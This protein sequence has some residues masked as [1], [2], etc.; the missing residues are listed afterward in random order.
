MPVYLFA[1]SRVP[2]IDWVRAVLIF[3]IL[4]LLVYPS[5]NGYNSYM[6]RDTGSIGGIK[7]PLQPTRQLFIVTLILDVLAIGLSLLIGSLFTT[8]VFLYIMASKAYSFRGIR[9]KKYPIIGYLTV[10]IFQGAVI[11]FLVYHGSDMHWTTHVPLLPMIGASLLIGGFY[12]L[13]QI[14]QHDDDLK[15]GVKTISYMLGYKGT[16]LFTGIVYALAL[17][18]LGMYFYSSHL[19][20]RF[21][22]LVVFMSPVLVY[23][24][25]WLRKVWSN[26]EEANYD[27]TMRMNLIAS[28]CTNLGFITLLIMHI[29]E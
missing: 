27:N 29:N 20:E 23:Y 5:S 14:Y 28:V 4:H 3:I 12:P 2:N 26:Y 6:D 17:S 21:Y 11:F 16:F 19:I 1:L 10:V 9:L 7:K 25:I 22:I 13:T 8:G 24:F 15:D 18:V